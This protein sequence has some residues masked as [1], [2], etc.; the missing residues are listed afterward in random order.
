M[1]PSPG[2]I[3]AVLGTVALVS[4]G[5]GF[6]LESWRTGAEIEKLKGTNA[7]L[8]TVNGKCEQDIQNAAGAMAAM[9]HAAQELERQA[10]KAVRE[11]GP[12]VEKRTATITKIK[13]LPSVAQDQQ[14]EA[15]KREQ[16]EYVQ[17]RRDG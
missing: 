5:S 10:E 17:K 2:L 11:A 15:I 9:K 1:L 3:A 7:V 13:S 12:Q 4:F 6:A 16:V 8:H 14:C